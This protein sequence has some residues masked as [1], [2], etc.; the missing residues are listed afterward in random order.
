MAFGAK[1]LVG[2]KSALGLLVVE[3]DAGTQVQLED[4]LHLMDTREKCRQCLSNQQ[5]P[6]LRIGLCVA[7]SLDGSHAE[8]AGHA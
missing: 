3:A 6:W 5:A 7:C 2:N 1:A 8:S 4:A